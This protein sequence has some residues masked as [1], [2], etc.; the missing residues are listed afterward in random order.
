MTGNLFKRACSPCALAV[1]LALSMTACCGE[2]PTPAKSLRMDFKEAAVNTVLD[3]L[4]DAAGLTILNGET[5]SDKITII[6]KQP[7]TA[8]EALALLNSVLKEKGY[9]GIRNGKILKIVPIA[10]AKKRVAVYKGEDPLSVPQTD[11]MR[12]Q[13]VQIRNVTA[14]QLK[15]DLLPLMNA[16][17]ELIS[18]ADSNTLMITDTGIN[19]RRIMEM[20]RSVDGQSPTPTEVK[21]YQ[22][23]YANAQSAARLITDMFRQDTQQQGQQGRGG[24]GGGFRQFFGGGGG[25]PFG[26]PGGAN[27]Q[28]EE[29]GSRRQAKVTASADDRTNNVVV[30]A[31][32]EII[33]V[34]D[35]IIKEL[36]SNP[37]EE[38]AVFIYH[39]KNAYAANLEA[40]LNNLF[41][42]G[43]S[44][45]RTTASTR[46]G[47]NTTGGRGNNVNRTGSGFGG[48]GSGSSGFGG[49]G[50]SGF[51]GSGSSGFGGSGGTSLQGFG[52]TGGGG[53]TSGG[54]GGFGSGAS[55]PAG[56]AGLSGQV[57]VVADPDSNSLMVLSPSKDFD[58]IKAVIADLDRPVP[59]VVIKVLIAEVTHDKS[60]D[61][62]TDVSVLTK[63]AVKSAL[64]DF[65]VAA[66]TTGLITKVVQNDVSVALRA[67]ATEGKLEILS[68]PYIICSDNQQSSITV[69]NE[70]PFI[71]SSRTTDT[72]QTINTIQYQDI[73]IIL[74]VTAHINDDGL[75]IMDV[76]PEVSGL[77]GQTVPISETVNAPVF[78]KRSALCRV[79]VRDGTTV[80]IGGLMEDKKTENNRG[81]P[82]LRRMPGLGY[83][84]GNKSNDKSKTELVIFL[85]P[86]V[87]TDPAI[88]K[89]MSEAEEC[90]LKVVPKAIKPG[91]YEE[92]K[93]GLERGSNATILPP[94]EGTKTIKRTEG[95]PKPGEGII[96]IP[97]APKNSGPT[98]PEPPP[99][100]PKE[101]E[102]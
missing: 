36:D 74:N 75:V 47:A 39:C 67:L 101:L 41:G 91:M 85:T 22:L 72:G 27:N 30:S 50:S 79:G 33:K 9:A 19:V 93:D 76:S 4:S 18:N 59:Q 38:Q 65:G 55:G 63:G 86:H 26:G 64:T 73:G 69:G 23:K 80:I 25:G 13:V 68:R 92:H 84:F 99:K 54:G 45:G 102:K 20:I 21:V 5:I 15:K 11:E 78:T 14:V 17:G 51:G 3:Y 29:G 71:V 82:I 40:T 1:A 77:T 34:I 97:T 53:R 32:P 8:D 89:P 48:S 56:A 96:I 24:A 28:Q 16:N 10:E 57:Y 90:G 87:A 88:L 49:S 12:T 83:L 100:P 44:R 37:A 31:P 81:I 95:M 7:M 70:V 61:A 35:N 43:S 62:G 94:D 52:S 98:V 42:T 6:S 66:Q 60:T 2:E 58:R 46:T